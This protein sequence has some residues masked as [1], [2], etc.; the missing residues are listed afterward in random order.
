MLPVALKDVLDGQLQP[1]H[2]Q[3]GRGAVSIGLIDRHPDIGQRKEEQGQREGKEYQ[4][5]DLFRLAKSGSING[6][7]SGDGLGVGRVGGQDLSCSLDH[8]GDRIPPPLDRQL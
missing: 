1:A 3:F 7:F 4:G 8:C 6:A 5:E 2:E